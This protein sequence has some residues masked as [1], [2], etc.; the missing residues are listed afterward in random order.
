MA[1]AS[2]CAAVGSVTPCGCSSWW[3]GITV[4]A[5]RSRGTLRPYLGHLHQRWNE[6]CTDGAV[7]HAEIRQLGYRGATRTVRRWLQPLRASGQP[8][9]K[10][11]DTPTVRLAAQWLTR[12]PDSLT[13][14]EALQLKRILARS[15]ELQYVSDAVRG[16]AELMRDRRG[17][18]LPDWIDRVAAEGC[19]PLRGFAV[20]LRRDLDAVTAGL[21]LPWNSGPVEGAVTRIKYLKRQMFGR[22]NFD[23]LRLR[24]INPN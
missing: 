1:R 7:L 13:A 19:P 5:A 11:S 3:A 23:L 6:G 16:F 14:E 10:V 24:I 12:H 4:R 9:P 15:P 21:S 8:A 18:E 20:N 2:R 22:A 17:R